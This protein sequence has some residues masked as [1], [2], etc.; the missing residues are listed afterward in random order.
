MSKI[1][2]NSLEQAFQGRDDIQEAIKSAAGAN[3]RCLHFG[4]NVME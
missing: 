3:P 1:D 4:G 2:L